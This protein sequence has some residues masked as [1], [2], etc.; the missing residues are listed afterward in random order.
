MSLIDTATRKKADQTI[1]QL[2]PFIQAISTKLDSQGILQSACDVIAAVFEAPR[3]SAWLLDAEQEN[4]DL[5]AQSSFS[6]QLRAVTASADKGARARSADPLAEVLPLQAIPWL[7]KLKRSKQVLEIKGVWSEFDSPRPG[8][9]RPGPVLGPG[10]AIAL[11]AEA[12][13]TGLIE[14][15][16]LSEMVL[17]ED[18]AR[19]LERFSKALSGWLESAKHYQKLQNYTDHLNQSLAQRTLELEGER[20][21]TQSILEALGEAVFVADLDGTI[22]YINQAAVELTGYSR[23]EILGQRM[24][25]WRS[26]RQTAELYTQMLARI[27]DGKAWRGEVINERKDGSLYDAAIT[28]AP[29]FGRGDH[30]H[31]KGFVSIQRDITPVKEAERLKDRFVSNVSH[32]LRTPLSVLTLLVGNL[33]SLYAVLDEDKRRKLI[34]NI[35]GHVQKLNDLVYSVLELSRIDS[36]GIAR[37]EKVLDISKLARE[38]VAEQMLLAKSKSLTLVF[39]G[40]DSLMV[41]GDEGHLRQVLRNLIDNAIKYTPKRGTITCE[42]RSSERIPDNEQKWPG[43]S[44]LPDGPWVG[45]R[46]ADNGIGIHPE[47]L[48]HLFERFY[49]V[50]SQGSIPGAG[51]GLSIAKELVELNDGQL[52][53]ASVPGEGSVFTVYLPLS[54]GSSS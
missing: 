44:D 4:L 50:K 33:D 46:V 54:E 53:V 20:D 9:T 10:W 25:L 52:A 29:L 13:L 43:R 38:L 42:C 51:L 28:V 34:R 31:L 11:V 36:G 45:I 17:A 8:D 15:K 47:D 35:R 6:S 37:D 16:K 3:V 24:R 39:I 1:G 30:K 48:P 49:R 19:E 7:N 23:V 2:E 18:Q 40:E 12:E 5:I 22:Q 21:R 27:D 14:I 41:N 26:H 32:E